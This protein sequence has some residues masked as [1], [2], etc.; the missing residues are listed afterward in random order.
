MT[1]NDLTVNFSHLDADKILED[2]SWL[3]G[4]RRVPILLAASGDAF[5][6]DKDS[7]IIHFLSTSNGTIEKVADSSA[8]FETLLRD[9]DFVGKYL[10]VQ[11]VGTMYQTGRRLQKGKIFSFKKPPIL[12]GEYKV[13]N[14]EESDIEVHFAISGQIHMQVAGIPSGT[15]IGSVILKQPRKWWRFWG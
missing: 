10:S 7:M 12:G 3:I 5:V 8:E 13:D 15:S 14:I 11:M 6:Q 1:L 4:S 2:W 9:K